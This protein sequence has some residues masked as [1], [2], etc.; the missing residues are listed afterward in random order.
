MMR[1]ATLLVS[2]SLFSCAQIDRPD[3]DLCVVNAP[4][5]KL[6]CFNLKRDYD[7]DGNLKSDAKPVFKPAPT[8]ES[9]NKHIITDPQ[10]YARLRAY[11]R[12]LRQEYEDKC[13]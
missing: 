3:T 7:K 4:G 12:T 13:D 8:I 5:K 6:T 1:L 9:V 11:I 10:G 2:F